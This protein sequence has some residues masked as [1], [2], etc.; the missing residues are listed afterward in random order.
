VAGGLGAYLGVDATAL[1][2]GFVIASILFLGGFGGPILYV[3]AWIL[4]PEE[5]NAPAVTRATFSGRPW[6]DWDR[7]ARS[8]ALVLGALAL[9]LI[10]SF[11][12]WPWWHWRTLPVWLLLIGL[13]LWALARRRESSWSGGQPPGWGR[14]AERGGPGPMPP[15]DPSG[16]HVDPMFSPGATYQGPGAYPGPTGPTA[17]DDGAPADGGTGGTPADQPDL[18][19]T[20]SVSGAAAAGPPVGSP[21]VP[22][23]GVPGAVVAG[24]VVAGA[25]GAPGPG[26]FAG[27]GA[28]S[29]SD[30]GAATGNGGNGAAPVPFADPGPFGFAGGRPNSGRPD[31]S[32]GGN[33]TGAA[34]AAKG[35]P[36]TTPSVA[37]AAGAPVVAAKAATS[38]IVSP[39]APS[40][41][42]KAPDPASLTAADRAQAEEAAANWAAG[43]LRAAGVPAALDSG[44]AAV[45]GVV[46]GA[47]TRGR[48]SRGVR[49]AVRVLTALITALVLLAALA[50]VTV[51]LGSGSSLRGGVGKDAF[52]PVSASSVKSYYRLGAGNLD[53]NL[54]AVQ[55]PVSGKNVQVTLGLGH[56]TIEV[57]GDAAVT[58]QAHSGVGQV[59]VFGQSASNIQTTYY[60]GTGPGTDAPHLNINAHVGMGDIQVTSG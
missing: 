9:A 20:G 57:P 60:N 1:R 59:Q 21:G 32:D 34:P 4:V 28:A 52:A 31:A 54:S 19:A 11:G 58:V 24:A 5:G 8:W 48:G 26:P 14:P 56:M 43:Q 7:S 49:R 6:Q 27:T 29:A 16:A 47:I 37:A 12:I 30:P 17:A 50:V 10:W 53:V 42:E 44:K 13:A 46:T 3:I 45:G 40:L 15:R 55:F 36:A 18:V 23:A 33:S 22:G 51:T 35:A 25:A 2:V 39:V 38:N 41:V